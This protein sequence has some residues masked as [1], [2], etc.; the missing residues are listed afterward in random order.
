MLLFVVCVQHI[1]VVVCCVFT[2][3]SCCCLLASPGCVCTIAILHYL[4]ENEACLYVYNN[5][6]IFA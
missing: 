5:I 4:F 1:R 3:P 2:V 6:M